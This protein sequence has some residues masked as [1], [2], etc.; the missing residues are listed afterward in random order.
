MTSLT[1][2]RKGY[3]LVEA[4]GVFMGMPF[5]RKVAAICK[6]RKISQDDIALDLDMTQ[7][8]VSMIFKKPIDNIKLSHAWAI[9]RH[10]GVSLDY[11]VDPD[12]PLRSEGEL[13]RRRQIDE[14]IARMGLEKAYARLAKI[15][16]EGD[17]EDGGGGSSPGGGPDVSSGNPPDGTTLVGEG[18]SRADRAGR[19][20][21][22]SLGRSAGP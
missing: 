4:V 14:L 19:R 1:L 2:Q 7:G 13:L 5:A 17:E 8:N 22:R 20:R 16:D 3:E 10:L 6:R 21:R 9:A 18:P 11:L 12:L 15:E